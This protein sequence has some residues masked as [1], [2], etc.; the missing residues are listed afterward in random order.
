MKM[1]NVV[2]RI[3]HTLAYFTSTAG[4]WII[5][6]LGSKTHDDAPCWIDLIKYFWFHPSTWYYLTDWAIPFIT[7]NLRY[8]WF[9]NLGKYLN[10]PTTLNLHLK[11]FCDAFFVCHNSRAPRSSECMPKCSSRENGFINR[12]NVW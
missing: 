10:Q 12:L 11:R 7:K 2:N 5:P 1:N 3:R 6:P 9:H 4:S 8:K